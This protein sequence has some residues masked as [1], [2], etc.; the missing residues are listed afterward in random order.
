M[1]AQGSGRRRGL[2]SGIGAC[3]AVAMLAGLGLAVASGLGSEHAATQSIVVTLS[4]GK[5]TVSG[6]DTLVAGLTKITARNTG[7][8]PANFLLAR[9]R[10][11]KTLADLQ[12]AAQR[13]NQIP[14][15]VIIVS[16]SFFGVAPGQS[17][18]TTIKLPPG[19]YVT[20]QPPD[21]KGIGPAVQFSIANGAAG[22]SPPAT[23]GTVLLYDYGISAPKSISGRGTL[24][25]NNIGQNYHFLEALR[26][27]PGVSAGKII[28]AI[29][30]G[31]EGSG[32]PPFQGFSIIGVVAPSAINY[33]KTNLPPG[34]Y[35]IAC[36][37]SNRHSAGHNHSQFG[38]VRKL[39]VK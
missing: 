27:N 38:M 30:S 26:L 31:E 10:P 7:S 9:L 8:A 1:D 3:I 21:G 16:T 6:A 22:G 18:V 12:A 32:P 25:I 17:F 23:T 33:V 24:E 2:R 39:T 5:T 20:T 15:G 19:D 14:E 34:T 29:R 11:G 35:V 4:K 13:T 28:A 36:F 37:N